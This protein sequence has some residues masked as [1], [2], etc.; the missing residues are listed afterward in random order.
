MSRLD[1]R[2]CGQARALRGSLSLLASVLIVA[3]TS[4]AILTARGIALRNSE[5]ALDRLLNL[6]G[7]QALSS[8]DRSLLERYGLWGFDPAKIDQAQQLRDLAQVPGVKDYSLRFAGELT[9]PEVLR[10]QVSQFAKSRVTLELFGEIWQRI[11]DFRMMGNFLEH[12]SGLQDAIEGVRE[13]VP[14]IPATAELT[15]PLLRSGGVSASMGTEVSSNTLRFSAF[16]INRHTES[17]VDEEPVLSEEEIE[18]LDTGLGYVDDMAS[19]LSGVF[20]QSDDFEISLTDDEGD[21]DTQ[22]RLMSLLTMVS[23]GLDVMQFE[24]PFVLEKILFQEYVLAQFSSAVRGPAAFEKEAQNFQTLSRQNMSKLDFSE[25]FEA[26]MI[27]LAQNRAFSARL[28]VNSTI[29]A[30]RLATHFMAEV[31]DAYRMGRHK[32]AAAS[33]SAAIAILSLGT[34]VLEPASIAYSLAL[35]TAAKN[36]LLDLRQILEGRGVALYPAASNPLYQVKVYYID[37]LRI[38]GLVLP[39]DKQAEVAAAVIIKNIGHSPVTSI[40]QQLRLHN[41]GLVIPYERRWSYAV[42][43]D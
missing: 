29:G 2:R 17:D 4:T 15:K 24:V 14:A 36:M 3:I 39:I 6:Q 18:A 37:Y 19:D 26:E 31:S 5:L 30:T 13:F 1:R 9:E 21:S 28:F 25:K 33:I 10:R 43:T 34:V 11:Q 42:S 40:E 38:L 23:Q 7:Q 41:G 8:Y 35:V 12:S 27:L 22:S 20:G 32:A 16:H